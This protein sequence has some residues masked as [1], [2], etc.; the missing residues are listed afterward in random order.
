M[1][2]EV[3][4]SNHS[5]FS[6][7]Q[8]GT[9]LMCIYIP[10]FYIIQDVS[11]GVYYAGSKY[12]QDANPDS[13]MSEGG[14]LTSSTTVKQIIAERGLDTFVVRKIKTFEIGKEALDYESRFLQKVNAANNACFYNKHNNDNRFDNGYGTD[15]WKKLMVER[16][17]FDNPS[18]VPEVQEKKKQT[19]LEKYGFDNPLKSPEV[20]EKKKQT[21]LEKYGFDNPLKS[22]EI[23]EKR[24][25]T[26]LEKYGVDHH[27]KSPEVQEKMKQTCL[28]KYGVEHFSQIPE[29]REKRKETW[30]EK[31]GVDH[32]LKSPEVQEKIKQTSMKNYGVDHHLKSPKIQEKRKQTLLKKYGVDHPSKATEVKEK[33]KQTFLEKYGVDNPLKAP[34]VQ[35]KR[36]KSVSEYYKNNKIIWINNGHKTKMINV[37]DKEKYLSEGWVL[38]RIKNMNK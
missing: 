4:A 15:S 11:N 24:K 12:G 35:E 18:K 6:Y 29:V 31:Y 36:K 3:A 22:P 19:S 17:G 26:L 28:E 14:Y 1:V 9:Q 13:F 8:E 20:Q 33:M 38:G 2:R 32:P 34:E 16:Y 7:L 30:L 10:Y 21:S 25:Q 5:M 23:Q 37:N 27:L